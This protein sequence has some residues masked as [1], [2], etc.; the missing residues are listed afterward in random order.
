MKLLMYMDLGHLLYYLYFF[1]SVL[2]SPFLL[3]L[4][5]TSFGSQRKLQNS[6]KIS[7]SALPTTL[8]PLTVDHNKL[9]KILQEIRIPDHLAR[10]LRNLYSGQAATVRTGHRT[11]DWFKIWK[12]VHQGGIMP[13]CLFN[14]HA[15]YIMENATGWITSWN[16]D[17]REKHQ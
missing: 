5:L 15:E 8:K 17:C 2:C 13:L 9:W 10:L 1:P 7:T 6:R 16:Q 12:G 3:S 11:S 4:L 14:L